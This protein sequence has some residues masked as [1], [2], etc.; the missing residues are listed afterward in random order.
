MR[1]HDPFAR[2]P[3]RAMTWGRWLR[4]AISVHRG[5]FIFATVSVVLGVTAFVGVS[6]GTGTLSQALELGQ[7]AR[8][9]DQNPD[10]RHV[11]LVPTGVWGALGPRAD[12]AA[13][14]ELRDVVRVEPGLG[15]SV[16]ITE[17]ETAFVYGQSLDDWKAAQGRLPKPGA[18]EVI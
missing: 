12:A 3:S 2:R 1:P 16:A 7:V 9:A 6:I 14:G 17:Q 4:R 13:I 5:R 18:D 8:L 11:Y 10:A 15:F